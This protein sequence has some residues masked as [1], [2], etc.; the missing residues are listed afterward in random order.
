MHTYIHTHTTLVTL[1]SA[2]FTVSV[3]N[4]QQCTTDQHAVGVLTVKESNVAVN[5]AE[6]KAEH[7]IISILWSSFL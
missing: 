1:N 4:W 5:F 2:V 6:R 7:F 3:C